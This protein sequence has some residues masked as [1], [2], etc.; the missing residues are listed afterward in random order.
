[1]G[2]LSAVL[3]CHAVVYLLALGIPFQAQREHLCSNAAGVFISNT[4][5]KPGLSQGKEAVAGQDLP[6]GY[7]KD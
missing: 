3:A 4:G 2:R 7:S 6:R 5:L 1:M